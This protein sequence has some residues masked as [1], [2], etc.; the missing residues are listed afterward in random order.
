MGN[1]IAT[2]GIPILTSFLTELYWT[3]NYRANKI[4]PQQI[5]Q[6]SDRLKDATKEK[7]I[8]FT[9]LLPRS[10]QSASFEHVVHLHEW[11]D[12]ELCQ[13]SKDLALEFECPSNTI[14]CINM[15]CNNSVTSENLFCELCIQTCNQLVDTIE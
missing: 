10:P 4:A 14:K 9:K 15:V 8:E 11:F 3:H 2:L 5:Y 13:L 12:C 6:M 1:V 7:D